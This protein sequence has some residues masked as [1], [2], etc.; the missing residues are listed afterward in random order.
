M[1]AEWKLSQSDQISQGLN[2]VS[3]SSISQ[4]NFESVYSSHEKPDFIHK[5]Y[6]QEN[7]DIPH[8]SRRL[9]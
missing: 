1:R 5:N 3:E 2:K 4:E 7:E 6:L 9:R 8:V